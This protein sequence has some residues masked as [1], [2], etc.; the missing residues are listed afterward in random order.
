MIDAS[1]DNR[2]QANM[3]V[4][5]DRVCGKSPFGEQHEVRKRV[6]EAILK[7]AREGK[8]TLGALTQAGEYALVRSQ[9]THGAAG[10]SS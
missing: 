10:S 7:A 8:F 4:A 9:K 6:A 5:L 2:T 3:E 1:F